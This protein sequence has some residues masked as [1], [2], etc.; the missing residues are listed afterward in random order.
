VHL[1]KN[2]EGSLHSILSRHFLGT[3]L[4]F[5][6]ILYSQKEEESILHIFY[7]PIAM[8]ARPKVWACGCSLAGIG[9]SKGCLS[10]VSV[11]CCQ[12]RVSASGWSLV[13]RSP[14]ECSVSECDREASIM[15]R[16]WSIR[17]CS[18]M[19]KNV[20]IFYKIYFC[21]AHTFIFPFINRRWPDKWQRITW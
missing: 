12:I 1:V 17:S 8:A 10:L 14:T 15:R 3:S 9:G 4:S 2:K 20:F 7:L 13:Q 6:S 11:V 5:S 18:A 16:P 19:D 21:F